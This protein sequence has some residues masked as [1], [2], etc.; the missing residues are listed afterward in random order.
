MLALMC[1]L[2]FLSSFLASIEPK[3]QDLRKLVV[4]DETGEIFEKT[5]VAVAEHP[6]FQHKGE[7]VYQG[8]LM[9]GKR[10]TLAQLWQWVR[11]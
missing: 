11:Y 3:I 1:M 6:T 9:Y 8:I 5:Q 10:P 7:L 2:I 4:I